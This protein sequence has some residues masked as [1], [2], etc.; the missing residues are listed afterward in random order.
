MS[1]I[2]KIKSLGQLSFEAENFINSKIKVVTFK[3]SDEVLLLNNR[4]EFIYYIVSGMLRGYY[5]L[6]S[7]EV[8]NWIAAEDEFATSIY[9]FL[10]GSASYEHIEALENTKV[11]AISKTDLDELFLKFPETERA[12]R[13][14]MENYYL[15]LEER[16][17]FIQFKT[18]KERYQYFFEKRKEVLKR[19]PLGCIA[20][21][22]GITQETLSRIRAEK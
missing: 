15:R 3:K 18:A 11:E 16:I 9:S 2:S 22:L 5:F 1:L 4:C 17:L 20:S 19:A 8:T 13:L 10:S 6:D 14:L 12:G 21:Y 7:K